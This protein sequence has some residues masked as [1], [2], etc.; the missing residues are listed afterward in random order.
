[1]TVKR[2]VRDDADRNHKVKCARPD[3]VPLIANT[4]LV[5]CVSLPDIVLN[6][7]ETE[8]F[9]SSSES[10]VEIIGQVPSDSDS[11]MRQYVPSPV[12]RLNAISDVSTERL[13]PLLSPV[14]LLVRVDA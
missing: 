8:R 9:D 2:K 6:I 13:T 7:D 4:S 14:Q 12:Y 3:P 1:M 10:E 11:V 5:D